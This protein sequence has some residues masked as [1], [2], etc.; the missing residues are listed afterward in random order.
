MTEV[1]TA[2]INEALKSNDIIAQARTGTGKTLGFLLP[3][4]SNIIA[5]DASLAKKTFAARPPRTTADDIRALIISPTREL[6]EQ[7]AAEARRVTA[8][9]DI[10]VQTA[11]G[12]T[13]RM[14]GLRQMQREGSHILVGTPGRLKDIFSDP[15]SGVSAPGLN[16]LVFDEAD[17]LLDQGFWPEIQEI[18]RL[19]PDQKQQPRQTLMFSA[20]VPK[21]VV[22]LVNKVLKPGF[23]FVRTVRDDEVPTHQGVPQHLVTV[24]GF[25][26][27]LPTL[28]ELCARE[29]AAA[30][31]G[32][33]QKRPFKAI[34][35]FN[36]TAE[37]TLASSTFHNLR[38]SEPDTDA[39]SASSP[40]FR[41]SRPRHPLAPAR[42][43]EIHARLTQ[44]ARTRS[45]D[46]FRNSTSGILFSSDVTAR[47]MDFPNVTHVIQVGVPGSRDTYIHRIGR[48]ARAGKEGEG[49]L[50]TTNLEAQQLS[51]RLGVG[52]R[53]DSDTLPLRPD[54]S[55]KCAQIDMTRE[56]QIPASAAK[57]LTAISA[58]TQLVP[59]EEKA[60]TYLALLGVYGW[61]NDKSALVRKMND[62]ARFGWGMATPPSIGRG[63]AQRLGIARV[64]GLNLGR[65]SSEGA[66]DG[67][68]GRAERGSRSVFGNR[69]GDAGGGR[70]SYDRAGAAGARDG[71]RSAPRRYSDGGGFGGGER[72]GGERG[73]GYGGGD[74]SFG[75]RSRSGGRGG[76]EGY[77]D[78]EGGRSR[79]G[80]GD[81][82]GGRSFADSRY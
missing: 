67:G 57:I 39:T 24:N 29:V 75:A 81:R 49:W 43:F 16:A 32:S 54:S 2:T 23:Q 46:N 62:W 13:T 22:Q 10:I 34:V 65:D 68:D 42:I 50:L 73:S 21:E 33:G 74:R 35:Y 5:S 77:G 18:M 72:G 45:A 44:A 31:D 63:L 40:M 66:A 41:Q 1:Q 8:H 51:D 4:L 25:E 9:T 7:I 14:A 26:N 70:R 47:G 19:L 30:S 82:E 6:A 17:R 79:E 78:R 20:T 61:L 59:R 12:G 60:K 55:L 3:L 11:V 69:G 52:R 38:P 76:R 56:A 80:Y 28:Y 48:T 27:V 37:V 15:H 53:A 36:S 64:D 71:E 58:A